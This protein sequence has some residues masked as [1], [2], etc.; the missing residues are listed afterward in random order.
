MFFVLF[1]QPGEFWHASDCNIKELIHTP[2]EFPMCSLRSKYIIML[3]YLFL[4]SFIS[5]FMYFVSCI[6]GVIL[7]LSENVDNGMLHH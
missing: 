2:E 6:C 4:L 3:I 1:F 5:L 7:F